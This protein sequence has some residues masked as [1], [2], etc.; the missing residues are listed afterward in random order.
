M[1]LN[2]W[3]D[4]IRHRLSQP[5]SRR[6]GRPASAAAERLEDR[7]LL[8]ATTVWTGSTLII[9]ATAGEAISITTDSVTN[10]QVKIDGTID[11]SLPVVPASTVERIEIT[12]GDGD[13]VINLTNINAALF[14]FVDPVS[15]GTMPITVDGGHGHDTIS[16]STD[17]DDTL[18]GGDGDDVINGGIGAN[19]LDGGDGNDLLTGGE[20]ND[21][22]IGEDGQDT[23]LAGNGDDTLDGGNGYDSLLGHAGSDSI[24]GGHGRDTILG[25]DDSDTINGNDGRDWIS[26]GSGDDSLTG[27]LQADTL[28]AGSGDDTAEGNEGNDHIEGGDDD[29]LLVGGHDQDTMFGDAGDDKLNG[30]RHN[31]SMEG[32]TGDDTILGGHGSDYLRGN[33]NDDRLKGQGG[34]DTIIGR[35]GNDFLL[36][37][38]GRDLLDASQPLITIDN[39]RIDP[40]GDSGQQLA[41][42][43]VTLRGDSNEAVSVDFATS[44][45]TATAGADYTAANGTLVWNSPGDQT[46]TVAVLGD[47]IDESDEENFFVNLANPIGALIYDNL[48]EARIVDDDDAPQAGFGPAVC[49]GGTVIGTTA[50]LAIGS[51]DASLTITG[52]TADGAMNPLDA[53]YDPI[54]STLAA[55]TIYRSYIAYRDGTTGA[56]S[57]L[58]SGTASMIGDSTQVETNFVHDGLDMQLCQQVRP[59]LDAS[60]ALQGA[61]LAQTVQVTNPAA[62][63]ANFELV[64]YLDGDLD[65]DGSLIDG[66]GRIVTPS[67]VEILFETDSGGSGTTDTTFV[68]ITAVG[69]TLPTTDRFEM[70]QFPSLTFDILSGAPLTDTIYQDNDGDSFVDAGSEYDIELGLRNTFSLA[71]GQTTE[72]TTHTLFGSGAPADVTPPSQPSPPSSPP[73]ISGSTGQGDTLNGGNGNDTLL[74]SE[75]DDILRGGVARDLIYGGG[76]NDTILG[77][78]GRD[79]IDGGT[80]DDEIHGNTGNDSIDGGAGDDHLVWSPGEA[81]D[82]PSGGAGFDTLEI[83]GSAADDSYTIS[84]TAG[85]GSKIQITDG[86]HRLTLGSS[87]EV[88]TLTMG[89]GNDTVTMED[90][91]G[92]SGTLLVIYGEDGNDTLN[93]ADSRVGTVRIL[94]DGGDGNDTLTGSDGDDSLYGGDGNDLIRGGDGDDTVGAGLGDDLAYG[95][96]GHDVIDGQD[97]NDTL[98]GNTGNDDLRGG[99]GDDSLTGGNDDDSLDGGHGDDKLNGQRGND[100]LF[101]DIG[102]DT[103]TGGSGDDLLDGGLNDDRLLGNDGDD[104]LRGDDGDDELHGHDGD[105]LIGGGDGNDVITGDGGADLINGGDGDDNVN[106]GGSDDT[107]VGGDGNDTLFG[108]SGSDIAL[109]ENGDDRVFGQGGVQDTLAGG[110]GNDLLSGLASEIDEAFSL[111]ASVRALLDSV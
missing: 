4:S 92:V 7:T 54:G 51:G 29:D 60:G 94:L 35:S 42:F 14:S 56:R 82:T 68:G 67:G 39:V 106:A 45:G 12:G 28:L 77:Q 91:K 33:E 105:D 80:G 93:A 83:E 15:G 74:G 79:T 37:G 26:G 84:K 98:E 50:P 101:G 31:D 90:L 21:L 75:M 20:G 85:G 46:I 111:D 63:T 81:N 70:D 66:G 22:L 59:L 96:G 41:T 102:A 88:I 13:N 72:Y 43:T 5:T 95:D 73:P 25:G 10:V 3:I 110:E 64:R 55:T 61:L 100:Q 78:G 9:S 52:I 27:G 97:G 36:G 89:D 86:S 17:L 99:D 109:G 16:G 53:S 57:T 108:G 24:D 58:N 62:T 71:S 38:T 1:R 103:L 49:S 18:V 8:S 69:G 47:A 48:G 65:F 104:T 23:L 76:G 30:K 107:I 32:G 87:V 34:N 6:R 2:S 19:H 44:D 11:D 40:E